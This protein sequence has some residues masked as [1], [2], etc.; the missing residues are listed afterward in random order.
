MEFS[1]PEY[2]C[3]QLFPSAG[4]LPNPEMEPR[5]PTL[6]ADSLPT[7]PQRKP[8]HVNFFSYHVLVWYWHLN[9]AG[10]I[11]WETF[12]FLGKSV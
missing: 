4:D 1:R 2:W 9:N 5:S 12:Y 3:E 6:Q 7:E 8:K 10:I 11:S